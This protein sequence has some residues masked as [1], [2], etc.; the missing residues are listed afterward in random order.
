MMK[1]SLWYS[2]FIVIPAALLLGTGFLAWQLTRRP[3]ATAGTTGVVIERGASLDRISRQLAEQGVISSPWFF[4]VAVRL[5]GQENK[6]Q[7][8]RYDLPQG[9]SLLGLVEALG[10]A[11]ANQVEV[12]LREGE[13]VRDLAARLDSAGVI[14]SSTFLR[15][16]GLPT[17]D[18]RTLSSTE[19]PLL[20]FSSQFSFLKDKPAY[21]GFE[22]YL[23]PDTYRFAKTATAEEIVRKMLVN[24]QEKFRSEWPAEAARQG[25]TIWE[26]VTMASLLEKEVRHPED[27]KLVAD[28]FWRRLERGQALQS[29][30]TLSYVLDDTTAAHSL[31][32]LELDSPYNSYRYKGLPPT[33]IG[34]PGATALEAALY[35]TPNRY[36]FFLSDPKTGATIFA[37]T[38]EGH[39]KNK[40]Q[41]LK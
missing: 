12:I 19:P 10:R 14:A 1:K 20:D 28:L 16:A 21:Y 36:N 29:D 34:N 30:A 41:Y 8:G 25:K 5:A 18:Y 15:Q 7:A 31:A 26:I 24:F 9:L 37:E 27:M 2:I 23:F 11:E 22:G 39:I 17:V 6:L 38:F 4:K 32:D 3:A 33:P 40:Q 13:S 35:P